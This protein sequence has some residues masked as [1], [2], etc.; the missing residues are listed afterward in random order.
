LRR[1]EPGFLFHFAERLPAE[2]EIL[3]AAEKISSAL[4]YK[5]FPSFQAPLTPFPDED[6]A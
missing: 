5:D 2:V 1:P 4:F 6:D 3:A